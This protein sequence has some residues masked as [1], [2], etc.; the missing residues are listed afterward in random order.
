MTENIYLATIAPPYESA[1]VFITADK[2]RKARTEILN[3]LTEVYGPNGT[4]IN[5][6]EAEWVGDKSY[7]YLDGPDVVESVIVREVEH[8]E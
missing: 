5:L 6:K 8:V 7:A 3:Y 1:Q 2:P 4:N